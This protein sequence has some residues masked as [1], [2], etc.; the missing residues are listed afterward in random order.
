[1]TTVTDNE[2]ALYTIPEL[3]ERWLVSRSTIFNKIKRGR[4]K[5]RLF[6]GQVGFTVD[7]VL[8]YESKAG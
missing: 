6:G 5:S 2:K 3:M 8:G 7:D 1:M 4:L